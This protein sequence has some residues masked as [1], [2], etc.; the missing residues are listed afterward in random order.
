VKLIARVAGVPQKDVEIVSGERSRR[1]RVQIRG[2]EASD[3]LKRF[4]TSLL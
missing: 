4:E 3:V 2:L 1:K